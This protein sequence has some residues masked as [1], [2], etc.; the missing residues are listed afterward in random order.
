[1]D[2][3][4]LEDAE[5]LCTLWDESAALARDSRRLAAAATRYTAA[6][7]ALAARVSQGQP[8]DPR[9]MLSELGAVL[10][11]LDTLIATRVGVEEAADT[12]GVAFVPNPCPHA[13][14]QAR[15]LA[16][17]RERVGARV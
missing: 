17:L 2:E 5:A 3:N 4:R 15:A 6:V 14:V 1:M 12:L 13:V 8:A 9:A 16:A 11:L 10:E 7:R